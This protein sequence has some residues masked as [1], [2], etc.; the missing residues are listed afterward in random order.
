MK[1]TRRIRMPLMAMVLVALLAALWA[2][3]IRLGWDLPALQ[4]MLPG[5][6]GPLMVSG[7]LGTLISLERAIPLEKRWAYAAPLASGLG[8]LMLILGVP[9]PVGPLLLSIGSLGLVVIMATIVRRQ[10]ALYTLT[11]GIGAVAWLVG[12]LLWLGGR[13]VAEVVPWWAGFLVLTIVGERLELSRVARLPSYSQKIFVFA[14]AL[15][16]LGLIISV[17]AYAAGVRL[18]N[19]G[20]IALALWLVRF[21]IARRTVRRPGMT[22][23]IA[24]NLLLGY[25][26]LMA[27]G[28][29]GVF[30]AGVTAG[31]AYDAW[32]HAIFLGFVFSMIF[33]HA[34]IILPAVIGLPVPFHKGLYGPM[35]LMQ[36]S[37]VV[38][39]ASD[40]AASWSVRRW[41]GLLNV[42]AILWFFVYVAILM[43]RE[44][45]RIRRMAAPASEGQS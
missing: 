10:T 3:L 9:D 28:L 43:A 40:L 1:V 4:P 31:F 7:F 21:D 5:L 11:M 22:R 38:R 39:V 8:A 29:L 16:V 45:A 17:P 6:H 41:S 32:L 24:V 14:T 30:N 36:V 27:G 12:N 25:G 20:F 13:S 2:G 26:W 34:L 18:A 33:A 37:L 44:Q 15:V 42:I 35:V 19:L 23:Y